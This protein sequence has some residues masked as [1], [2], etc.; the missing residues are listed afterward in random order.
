VFAALTEIVL[1]GGA[2]RAT[3]YISEKLVVKATVR[4][5]ERRG[6]H[7][8]LVFTIGRPNYAEREFIKECKKAG[9]SFPV[10]KVQIQ[11]PKKRKQ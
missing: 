8:E 6:L 4:N 7:T 3:K 11:W 1:E 2:K 9:E 5:R 10:K